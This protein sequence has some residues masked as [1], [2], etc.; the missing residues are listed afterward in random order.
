M[1]YPLITLI[2][3]LA[4]ATCLG[5]VITVACSGPAAVLD[6]W[7]RPLAER[8]ARGELHEGDFGLVNATDIARTHRVFDDRWTVTYFF[9][10]LLR[11]EIVPHWTTEPP[12]WILDHR[13]QYN[14][15]TVT[16][17]GA[18]FPFR[19][20]RATERLAFTPAASGLEYTCSDGWKLGELPRG[21]R[22]RTLVVPFAP[23]WPG[24]IANVAVWSVTV[25]FTSLCLA[26]LRSAARRR[27]SLCATCAYSRKGLATS[28]ACP[29]CGASS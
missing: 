17:I 16:H 13:D 8:N 26:S 27:R 9:G 28:A 18:G 6:Q 5:V 10:C 23:I 15:E 12:P 20:F 7:L 22:Q 21:I 2:R 25:A 14:D 11:R 1:A 4:R 29:E 3:R 19:A 24:L